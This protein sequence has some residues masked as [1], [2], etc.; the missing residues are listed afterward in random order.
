MPDSL[1]VLKGI[2]VRF[3]RRKTAA[4]NLPFLH[5]PGALA[6]WLGRY[7]VVLWTSA[8]LIT[9]ATLLRLVLLLTF[10]DTSQ[11]TLA[12]WVDTFFVGLRFDVM[13]AML[14]QLPQMLHM[15]LHSNRKVDGLMS[16]FSIHAGLVVTFAVMLFVLA[17]EYCFFAEFD[18]RFNYIA[19]EY[20]VYPTEVLTNIWESYPLLPIL[21][22]IAVVSTLIYLPLRK[23]TR[24]SLWIPLP[25]PRRYAMLGVWVLLIGCLW[26]T[27]GRASMKVTDNRVVN[28]CSGNGAWTFVEN[29]W[30]SRFDYD[31]FY[32]TYAK[33]ESQQNAA[34]FV[35][36]K[37][38]EPA[39]NAVNPLDRYIETGRPR[40]N[41]NVV[42][43]LEE[44]LGSDYIG[45]LQGKKGLT[46]NLDRHTENA[47][48]FDRFFATGNRTARALEATI[49][50][51][52][53]IP[54]ESI[55]K[56]DH[57]TNVES[58]ARILLG[59]GYQ[60][61]F[62]YGGRGLFDGMR[63]FMLQNGFENFV[64]YKDFKN[65]AFATV[66]GVS[67]D[68]LFDRTFEELDQ[69]H[70]Q[71]KPFFATVLTVSNH[72][73]FSYPDGKI[74]LPGDKGRRDNA[75]KF[76]DYAVGKFLDEAPSHAFYKDTVIVV[77]G[78]HGARVYGAQQFPLQS[79]RVPVWM[80]LPGGEKAGERNHVMSC[81]LDIAPTILGYL[82]GSYRTTMFGRD[83]LNAA[84]DD[85]RA[86]MQHNHDLALLRQDGKMTMLSLSSPPSSCTVNF[87]NFE[88]TQTQPEPDEVKTMVSLFQTA[89]DLY[90]ADLYNTGKTVKPNRT[91][92][93][94]H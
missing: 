20:L 1:D 24:V 90:Y 10:A 60:T 11:L 79:Y 22:G 55:L 39:T 14:F 66:W 64:E 81:S 30:T 48:L 67:D 3:L 92:A 31:A 70:K 46:P 80:F 18:S 49:T 26:L 86:I 94:N 89:N 72:Q 76:A 5:H 21:A 58:L 62:I 38:E 52:L 28:Q 73:P 37:M 77:L 13:V 54:T 25:W 78:D 74:D 61:R 45:V 23:L 9:G 34:S 63:S 85:G 42:L 15:T 83:A 43:I 84:K 17:S 8:I 82:G 93:D 41:Y 2:Q 87:R 47:L 59:R 91:L 7:Q 51:L 88:T 65:P 33:S 69:M 68:I 36:R 56:R 29:A 75:V 50:G 16:R 35:F 32:P 53:P 12:Q 44:S 40:H 4:A 27:T 19:F 57:S 71:G 6:T